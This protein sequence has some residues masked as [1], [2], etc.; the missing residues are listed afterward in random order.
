MF[1]CFCWP[2]M[3]GLLLASVFRQKLYHGKGQ[4]NFNG[5]NRHQFIF[6]FRR[7]IYYISTFEKPLSYRDIKIPGLVIKRWLW[8]WW[9]GQ[10]N[11]TTHVLLHSLIHIYR[12]M[13]KTE[14][15]FKFPQR[16]PQAS[17]S[18]LYA[19]KANTSTMCHAVA[20]TR[21]WCSWERD[22]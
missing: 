8:R 16:N 2:N 11:M 12:P 9:W 3:Y 10:V 14:I 15:T 6:L 7:C 18:R 20:M 19:L 22:S 21:E 4:I 13:N 1:I 17:L 5:T